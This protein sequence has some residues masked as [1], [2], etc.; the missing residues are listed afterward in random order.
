MAPL[1]GITSRPRTVES[2]DGP[3]RVDSIYQ[4]YRNAV[5]AAGGVPVILPPVPSM[6][7]DRIL[8]AVDGV[9]LTGG[10]DLD[11]SVYG[12][13]T[14]VRLYGIDAERDA[15]ELALVRSVR[16]RT[17]PTLAICRG[18]QVV[19]VAFGGSLIPDLMM[20]TGL[21]SHSAPGPRA[22]LTHQRINIVAGT[23][24]ATIAGSPAIGVNS[25]HHQA[26]DRIAAGFRVTAQADDGVVEAMEPL[27][28]TW[29]LVAVQWHPEYL[30]PEGDVPSQRL[31]ADL[32]RAAEHG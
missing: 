12:M 2:A 32:V 22:R 7:V 1:I 15:F 29:H 31:F 19:N 20:A 25:L 26:V 11:P 23:R 8:D 21:N 16:E 9:M 13:S 10:G 6:H 24:L 28:D 5:L 3:A 27:D 18:L 4:T 30:A 17:I 14:F